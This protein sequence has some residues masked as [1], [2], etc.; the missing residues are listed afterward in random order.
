MAKLYRIVKKNGLR[1]VLNRKKVRVK[2]IQAI[3]TSVR[4]KQLPLC[5]A[6]H[7]EFEKSIFSE[8][9]YNKLNNVLNKK[10]SLFFPTNFKSVFE[11]KSYEM[12]S[13]KFDGNSES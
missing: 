6:H 4:R 10:A 2:V 13:F 3:M 5:K 12:K 8:L 1:T 11:G 9:E 7:L